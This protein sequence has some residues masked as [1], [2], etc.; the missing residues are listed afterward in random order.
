MSIQIKSYRPE[1]GK[2]I[3]ELQGRYI[4]ENP[5][6]TKFVPRE[7]YDRDPAN[8]CCAFTGDGDLVGYGALNAARAEPTSSPDIPDTIWIGIRVDPQVGRSREIQDALYKAILQ[9][10]LALRDDWAGRSTR[11]AISYPE[12]RGEEIAYF[13]AKGF[14]EFEALLQMGRDLSRPLQEFTLPT[15]VTVRRWA[16][17]SEQDKLKYLKVENVM[18][19][20]AP[21]TL[22]SLEYLFMSWEGGTP[23]TA[24]D[25]EGNI[26]GSVMAYW[27]GGELGLTEDV[28]V[29]PQWRRMGIAKHL[30]TEGMRFLRKNGLKWAGLEAKES[31]HPAVELYQSLGYQIGSREVQTG[32]YLDV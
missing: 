28:F 11:I 16:V 23:I 10:S 29:V 25:G 3:E 13:A 4:A 31:N 18:F 26:A 32:L 6:G 27:Y 17:E 24:F 2:A 9:R 8:V 20:D 21:R 7:R 22:E 19:P 14:V 1:L 30:I 15:G 5:N 12:S